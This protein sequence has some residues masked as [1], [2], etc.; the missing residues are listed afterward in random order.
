VISFK[1]SIEWYIN[2]PETKW[3]G[4]FDFGAL[5]TKMTKQYRRKKENKMKGSTSI[6]ID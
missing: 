1:S 2:K 5:Y 4:N 6:T 3:C